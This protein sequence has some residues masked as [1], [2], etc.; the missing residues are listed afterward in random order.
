[1]NIRPKTFTSPGSNLSASAPRTNNGQ[2][3]SR[4]PGSGPLQGFQS[5]MAG[6][7]DYSA[8]PG[9]GSGAAG[10]SGAN[11]PPRQP[12]NDT[13]RQGAP[14]GTRN[15]V[16]D[17][18]YPKEWSKS[19]HEQVEQHFDEYVNDHRPRW[20][21]KDEILN[22]KPKQKEVA[23]QLYANARNS[24]LEFML[25]GNAKLRSDQALLRNFGTTAETPLKQ[26]AK[27]G[28]SSRQGSI[29]NQKDW[30]PLQ[31]DAWL[32]GAVHG[33][34][35]FHI[36]QSKHDATAR[37]WALGPE[38]KDEDIW[39]KGK[40]PRDVP[41]PTVLGREL[42]ALKKMGYKTVSMNK[43][44]NS[45]GNNNGQARAN[46]HFGYALIP[47]EGG[48]PEHFTLET[49][50]RS[51][52]GVTGPDEIRARFMENAVRNDWTEPQKQK[53]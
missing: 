49:I 29:L 1:M 48:T 31:N 36:T 33:K 34:K 38:L 13:P 26:L 3:P 30:W 15:M 5:V 4:A 12:A 2:G 50:L 20:M 14:V 16:G 39:D 25:L 10:S 28:A 53:P 22:N 27:R 11:S 9:R 8:S 42:L 21:K 37:H 24:E 7:S 41:R 46:E 51:L 17:P 18:P 52:D 43:V 6:R 35:K 40:S 47:P 45:P 44:S 23:A 19:I 32:L